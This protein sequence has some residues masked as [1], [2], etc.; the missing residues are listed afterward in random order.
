MNC[1][2]IISLIDLVSVLFIS[3]FHQVY[4][5]ATTS[6]AFKKGKEVTEEVYPTQRIFFGL[7]FDQFENYYIGNM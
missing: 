5:D 2:K 4:E 3:C 7:S 6:E 1:K